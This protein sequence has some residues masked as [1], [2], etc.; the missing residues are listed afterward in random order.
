MRYMTPG[1]TLQERD[2]DMTCHA[3][4]PMRR[5][6]E[7]CAAPRVCC[8]TPRACPCRPCTMHGH[9]TRRGAEHLR[10]QA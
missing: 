9:F 6:L 10:E 1:T 7:C 3:H 4:A 2:S 5:H 8:N